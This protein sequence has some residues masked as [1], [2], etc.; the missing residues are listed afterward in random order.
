MIDS[1]L[2]LI[3]NASADSD[4]GSAKRATISDKNDN[5]QEVIIESGN[6]GS[7]DKASAM[8]KARD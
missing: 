3:V 6:A 2:E 5:A 4:T 8:K 7:G 1:Y